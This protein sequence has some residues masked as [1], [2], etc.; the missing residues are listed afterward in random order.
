VYGAGLW[1]KVARLFDEPHVG[2][3]AQCFERTA[4]DA[5][6]VKVDDAAVIGLNAPEPAFVVQFADAPMRLFGVC[7]YV[8]ASFPFIVLK[9]A[10]RRLEGIAQRNI[11]II[12]RL[13]ARAGAPG[14]DLMTRHGNAHMRGEEIALM[15]VPMGRFNRDV[16]VNDLRAEFLQLCCQGACPRLKRGRRVHVA[17]YDFKGDLHAGLCTACVHEGECAEIRTVGPE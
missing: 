10:S 9:L 13:I 1:S 17:K 3:D 16:A 2:A 4:Q 7:L 6:A 15:M 8:S 12:V 11:R 14:D 5:V